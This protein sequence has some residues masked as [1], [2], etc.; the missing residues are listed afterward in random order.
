MAYPALDAWARELESLLGASSTAP[1]GCVL[2][3]LRLLSDSVA[4]TSAV[5]SAVTP[6]VTTTTGAFVERLLP[7]AL[8]ASLACGEE[9]ELLGIELA[10]VL[11][12]AGRAVDMAES[13]MLIHAPL[14][15]LL[16]N[17]AILPSMQRESSRQFERASRGRLSRQ[18]RK[19]SH[20]PRLR[21]P[22]RFS[23]L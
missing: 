2:L 4:V 9:G 10:A 3:A 15:V 8:Q 13:R 14:R 5:T 19:M 16:P 1:P 20:M 22:S 21:R 17:P 18:R 11:V 12:T 7:S 23:S 6:A